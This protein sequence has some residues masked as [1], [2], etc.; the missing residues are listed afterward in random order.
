MQIMIF[1]YHHVIMGGDCY[2]L[3]G[4]RITFLEKE[5]SRLIVLNLIEVR[6]AS[7]LWRVRCSHT[8][9]LVFTIADD[10]FFL[11]RSRFAE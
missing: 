3:I 2:V 6:C 5:H 10:R 1:F 11:D 7:I 8:L 4:K 9:K